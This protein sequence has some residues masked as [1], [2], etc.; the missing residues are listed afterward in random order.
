MPANRINVAPTDKAELAWHA[1]FY[2]KWTGRFFNAQLFV[3][4]EILRL[5]EPYTPLRTGELIKSG[6][7]G[8]K[9]GTGLVQWTAIY[10]RRN[11]YSPRAVGSQTGPLRGPFWFQRMKATY[12]KSILK[13]AR[14]LA[15]GGS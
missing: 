2:P 1:D 9:I 13:G 5:S 6:T 3:D 4:S 11:Y 12:G 7:R 14:K 10:A 15:G 8:T